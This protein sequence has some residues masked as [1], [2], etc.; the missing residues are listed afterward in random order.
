MKTN[1]SI[2][3][4]FLKIPFDSGNPTGK[5]GTARSPDLILKKGIN[6]KINQSNAEETQKNITA[7]A[8]KELKAGHKICSVGGDHSITYGLV[9]ACSKIYKDL[10]LIYFDAHLDCE[11]D[12]IPPSHEDVIKAIVNQKFVKPSNI[13]IIG[14]RKFWKKEVSF[15]KKHNIT[16]IYA[17]VGR[18]E[19]EKYIKNFS[20]KHKHMYISVDID[21]FDPSI[22][23]DTGYPERHGFTEEE[24]RR[25]TEN[26][27]FK[28]I[29]GFD[30]VEV[31]ASN[32]KHKKT[33][34]VASHVIQF[35][36]G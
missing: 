18:S 16:V 35:L 4:K 34:T 12:F 15:I 27:D 30:L 6:V 32:E 17:P 31:S 3:Y 11:D 23:P 25:F 28:R 9:K 24:F 20:K 8:L 33:V 10:A 21:V 7:A 36:L 2:M 13:V 19:I 5:K 26:L 29:I 22:A 14:A 1:N